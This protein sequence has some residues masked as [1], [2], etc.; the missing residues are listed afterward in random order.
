MLSLTIKDPAQL[1]LFKTFL[2][3]LPNFFLNGCCW[4][5]TKEAPEHLY[6]LK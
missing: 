1:Q 2:V 3:K 6:E 5:W 4:V